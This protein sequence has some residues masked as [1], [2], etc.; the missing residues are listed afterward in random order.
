M[1]DNLELLYDDY[2]FEEFFRFDNQYELDNELIWSD[3][4]D[5]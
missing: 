1:E 4:F 5:D 3:E 2:W